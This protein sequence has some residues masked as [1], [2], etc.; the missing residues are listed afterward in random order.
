M[1]RSADAVDGGEYQKLS[2]SD[3]PTTPSSAVPRE[4]VEAE[5][6]PSELR[7]GGD[8]PEWK[9]AAARLGWESPHGG[10]ESPAVH[11]VQRGSSLSVSDRHDVGIAQATPVM[12][13]AE[14]RHRAG[15]ETSGPT[16]K[17]GGA[18]PPPKAN[19]SEDSSERSNT[20]RGTSS[21]LASSKASLLKL[22]TNV[23]KVVAAQAAVF[24]FKSV[25]EIPVDQQEHFL[26][27]FPKDLSVAKEQGSKLEAWL[28]QIQEWLGRLLGVGQDLIDVEVKDVLGA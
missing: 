28:K 20:S 4:R 25:I 7:V 13:G 15:G 21:A 22:Q 5:A 10:A 26:S 19:I 8:Q 2:T 16:A 17:T 24:K 14:Q 9:G 6:A 27:G 18:T 12:T 3:E 23:R 11:Q 1:M